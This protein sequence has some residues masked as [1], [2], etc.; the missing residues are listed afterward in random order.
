MYLVIYV[1]GD[2]E[3]D[4]NDRVFKNLNEVCFIILWFLVGILG[5]FGFSL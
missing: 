3:G 5:R 1:N 2:D 4:Y